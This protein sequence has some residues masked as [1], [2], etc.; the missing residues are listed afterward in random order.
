MWF[1]QT[2]HTTGWLRNP[3]S[4]QEISPNLGKTPSLGGFCKSLNRQTLTLTNECSNLGVGTAEVKVINYEADGD[5]VSLRELSTAEAETE[6]IVGDADATYSNARCCPDSGFCAIT[7]CDTTGGVINNLDNADHCH[8]ID[9]TTGSVI[10]AG[11]EITNGELFYTPPSD[12]G[13]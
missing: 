12:G 10:N 6:T 7:Y 11:D 8:F 9:A 13:S 3:G 2:Q 4:H 5:F 1:W